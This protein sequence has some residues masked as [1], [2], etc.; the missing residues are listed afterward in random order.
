MPDNNKT[1]RETVGQCAAKLQPIRAADAPQYD[2]RNGGGNGEE[3]EET[4]LRTAT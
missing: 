4:K 1:I 2:S 3:S